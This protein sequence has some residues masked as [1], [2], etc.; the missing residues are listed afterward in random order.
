M[1][2]GLKEQ[3]KS[4]TVSSRTHISVADENQKIGIWD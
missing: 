3:E 2:R 1:S 4:I